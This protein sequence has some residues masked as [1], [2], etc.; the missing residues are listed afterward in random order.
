[1]LGSF[2]AAFQPVAALGF[3]EPVLKTVDEQNRRD[4]ALDGNRGAGNKVFTL[5]KPCSSLPVRRLLP[6]F[7]TP[8]PRETLHYAIAA[9]KKLT[10]ASRG[11]IESCESVAMIMANSARRHMP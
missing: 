4:A 6:A 11:T 8:L 5:P 9:G 1:V 10:A 3:P 2:E 7:L